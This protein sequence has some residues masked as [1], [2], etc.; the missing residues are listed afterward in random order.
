MEVLCVRNG[1]VVFCYNKVKVFYV[2]CQVIC[3]KLFMANVANSKLFKKDQLCKGIDLFV[4]LL[5][6]FLMLSKAIQFL[7]DLYVFL[8]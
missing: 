8:W 2:Q 1:S 6:F 3:A 5:R 7:K 4:K